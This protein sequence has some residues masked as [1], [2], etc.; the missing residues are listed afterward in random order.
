MIEVCDNLYVGTTASCHHDPNGEYAV[1]H[2]CKYPCYHNSVG[3][4]ILLPNDE[5][6]LVNPC[7]NHLYLNMID[8]KQLKNIHL[9]PMISSALGFIEQNIQNK[10]ILIHCNQGQSRSPAIALIY[11]AKKGKI[12]KRSYQEAKSD[13]KKVYPEFS[14]GE[15]IEDYLE[16]NWER[17]IN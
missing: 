15:G 12:S 10:K 3:K 4:K 16:A 6:Y 11:L 14:P 17:L 8:A 5:K 7:E 2:A 1:I 13:F 9:E